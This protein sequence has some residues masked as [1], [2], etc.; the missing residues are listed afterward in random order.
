MMQNTKNAHLTVTFLKQERYS[1][2]QQSCKYHH[3]KEQ[4]EGTI[5]L[6]KLPSLDSEIFAFY[7][8]HVNKVVRG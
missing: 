4:N 1:N 3:T 6:K 7:C 8:W 5:H 2:L